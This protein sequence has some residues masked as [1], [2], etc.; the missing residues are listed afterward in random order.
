M[1]VGIRRN[2]SQRGGVSTGTVMSELRKDE[3]FMQEFR[4]YVKYEQIIT[5]FAWQMHSLQY[6]SVLEM[7]TTKS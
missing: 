5:D 3:D 6:E 7:K 1:T 2:D 4:E